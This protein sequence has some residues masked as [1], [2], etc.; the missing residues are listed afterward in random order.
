MC[1]DIFPKGQSV[2]HKIAIKAQSHS[3]YDAQQ[4]F[5]VTSEKKRHEITGASDDDISLEIPL[6]PDIYGQTALDICLNL[7]NGGGD[8]KRFSKALPKEEIKKR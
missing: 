1:F 8:P 5:E 6:L 2:L 4:L 3:F 7:D